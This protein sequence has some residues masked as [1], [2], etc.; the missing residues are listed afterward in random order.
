[1]IFEIYIY[2][3]TNS[4][5]YISTMRTVTFCRSQLIRGSFYE[6]SFINIFGILF[7]F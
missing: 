1:M 3:Y 6:M 7:Q 4:D 2:I 5:K